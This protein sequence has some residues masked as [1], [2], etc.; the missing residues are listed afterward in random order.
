MILDEVRNL[1]V[2]TGN[3]VARHDKR[4]CRFPG[5][6]L[7]LPLYLAIAS[8]EAF[9]RFLAVP[10]P[11]AFLFPRDAPVAALEFL[12]RFA[13]IP[14]TDNRVSLGVGGEGVQPHISA[15]LPPGGLVVNMHHGARRY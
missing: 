7:T 11:G 1:A 15:D 6:V 9:D 10:G 2:F 8:G 3:H 4:P 13:Q 5:K 14:G 12:L